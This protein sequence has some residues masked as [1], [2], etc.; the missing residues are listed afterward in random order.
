MHDQL[1]TKSGRFTTALQNRGTRQCSCSIVR[2]PECDVQTLNPSQPQHDSTKDGVVC[3]GVSSPTAG[4]EPIPIGDPG[5]LGAK[6]IWVNPITSTRQFFSSTSCDC[7][8]SLDPSDFFLSSSGK[9]LPLLFFH[10]PVHVA[11]FLR[12]LSPS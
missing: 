9:T 5:H 12:G 8:D 7:S 11:A 1:T 2:V 6:R 3:A 4:W 10:V